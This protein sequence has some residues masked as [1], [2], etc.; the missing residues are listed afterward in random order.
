MSTQ[1]SAHAAQ[2]AGGA[3]RERR[4]AGAEA[5]GDEMRRMGEGEAGARAEHDHPPSSAAEMVEAAAVRDRLARRVEH[6]QLA[7]PAAALDWMAPMRVSGSFS[8][9]DERLDLARAAPARR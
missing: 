1:P 3:G 8:S 6:L 9:R 4:E 7:A 5:E 2:R